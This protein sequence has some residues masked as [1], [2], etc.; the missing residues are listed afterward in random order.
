MD[1]CSDEHLCSRDCVHTETG[2]GARDAD[3]YQRGDKNELLLA[4]QLEGAVY[5]RMER[6]RLQRH[7]LYWYLVRQ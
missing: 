6:S 5:E 7:Y 3:D 2:V 4:R 1:V